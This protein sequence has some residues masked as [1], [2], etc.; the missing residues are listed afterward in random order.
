MIKSMEYINCKCMN[1]NME[2]K[3]IL[4]YIKLISMV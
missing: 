4:I 1:K 3:Y 2:I